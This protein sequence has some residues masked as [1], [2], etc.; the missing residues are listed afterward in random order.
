MR[1]SRT[2]NGLYAG[3]LRSTFNPQKG[4]KE[5]ENPHGNQLQPLSGKNL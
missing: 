4:L 5:S 2:K 1:K 3:F